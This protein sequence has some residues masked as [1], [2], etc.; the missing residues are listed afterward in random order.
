MNGVFGG[1]WT[2]SVMSSSGRARSMNAWRLE[3]KTRK[4]WSRRISIEAGWTHFGSKGSI[5]MRPLSIAARMSRSERTTPTEYGLRAGQRAHRIAQLAPRANAVFGV[6]QRGTREPPEDLDG[7]RARGS[8]H[9][10]VGR[11]I[12]DHDGSIGRDAEPSHRE[13]RE[14]GRRLGARRRIATEIDVD[15]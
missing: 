12:A 11:A 6:G 3:R 2:S 13:L 4:R 9:R 15:V 14:V 1:T 10:E 7:V 8:T 5:P